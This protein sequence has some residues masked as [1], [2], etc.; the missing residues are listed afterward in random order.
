MHLRG[1]P[2]VCYVSQ[3]T[4]LMDS[5]AT[6]LIWQEFPQ[7]KSSSRNRTKE[8]RVVYTLEIKRVVIE[9]IGVCDVM[10]RLLRYTLIKFAIHRSIS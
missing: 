6:C 2:I 4:A 5:W 1:L 8:H 9:T 7:R 10:L 3:I